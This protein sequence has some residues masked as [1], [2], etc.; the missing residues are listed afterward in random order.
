MAASSVE[1]TSFYGY[2]HAVETM[3]ADSKPPE[4]INEDIP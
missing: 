3:D 4:L 2:F 1:T